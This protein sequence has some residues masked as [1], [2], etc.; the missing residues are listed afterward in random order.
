VSIA[1]KSASMFDNPMTQPLCPLRDGEHAP[2][3]P[4][5]EQPIEVTSA[6]TRPVLY[7]R[8]SCAYRR[9]GIVGTMVT[10]WVHVCILPATSV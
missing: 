6:G 7:C 10:L 4:A 3:R 5:E 2:Q 9:H 8:A 1:E